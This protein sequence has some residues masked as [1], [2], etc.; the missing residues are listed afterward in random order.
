VPR[1]WACCQQ[2]SKWSW[3]RAH[4]GGS[5]RA[6]MAVYITPALRGRH[7]RPA[8]GD[9]DFRPCR[10]SGIARTMSKVHRGRPP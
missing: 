6:A 2:R 3:S 4:H 10:L 1:A 5:T 8:H 9:R 7:D